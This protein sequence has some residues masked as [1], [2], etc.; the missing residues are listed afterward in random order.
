VLEFA[1]PDVLTIAIG[2]ACFAVGA[3]LG[4]QFPDIDR[5]AFSRLRHR[6]AVTHSFLIPGLLLIGGVLTQV[7]WAD[8]LIA[9]FS[10][11]VAMHLAFDLF[12]GKWRG[13]ALI[14]VPK[15]G[16]LTRNLSAAWLFASVFMC[17]IISV[18][19]FPAFGPAG[20][21]AYVTVLAALY[22]HGIVAKKEHFA[23]GPLLTILTLG[24][25]AL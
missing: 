2:I 25:D 12:P 5:F 7:E 16:R 3:L 10:A 22:L 17:V 19:I 1:S 11:G 14:D 4:S 18:S 24:G 13:F 21:L 8:W 15:L 6:S 23:A 9:G 20:I